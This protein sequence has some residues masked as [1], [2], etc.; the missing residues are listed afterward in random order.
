[1]KTRLLMWI[2]WPSFLVAGLADGALFTV[3]DPQDLHFFG[4]ALDASRET[5]YTVGFL[6]CWVFCAL[7]SGLSLY[8]VPNLLKD[9]NQEDAESL[10]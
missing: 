8:L 2:L 1:M 10:I 4:G 3:I 7:S 6:V 9:L 5:A